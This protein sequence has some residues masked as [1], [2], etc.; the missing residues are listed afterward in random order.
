[1]TISDE[2]NK[3]I[4]HF[5]AEAVKLTLSKE[6]LSYFERFELK[7]K[8]IQKKAQKN[9][10]P[11]REEDKLEL[12][13][14]MKEYIEELMQVEGL[15]EED[16]F[17]K[18]Q[19]SFSVDRPFS[20]QEIYEKERKEYYQNMD[21]ALEEQIGLTYGSMVLLGIVLGAILG[22]IIQIWY[23]G[24]I[25]GVVLISMLCLGL[26]LGVAIGLAKHAKIISNK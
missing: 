19:A 1:M 22:I 14:Y 5:A 16:A 6:D 21:P 11:N 25:I 10:W 15:S 2:T 4:E 8:D 26:L 13:Q 17:C 12:E 18:A 3:K 24:Q 9:F 7:M 20:E 23:N